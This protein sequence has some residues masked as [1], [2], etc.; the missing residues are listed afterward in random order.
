MKVDKIYVVW[1]LRELKIRS[2]GDKK[3]GIIGYLPVF[4][5]RKNAEKFTKGLEFPAKVQ[6]VVMVETNDNS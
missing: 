4:E 2:E 3:K 5:T 6:S 1:A